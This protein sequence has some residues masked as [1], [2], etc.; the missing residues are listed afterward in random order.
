M[1]DA[2]GAKLGNDVPEGSLVH[3]AAA[4]GDGFFVYDVWESREA[5][6]RFRNEK[7]RPAIDE[8]SGGQ[9]GVDAD[10]MIWDLHDFR[11]A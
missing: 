3:T 1:Y 7:L 10:I 4:D 5:W 2:V 8:V 9:G 11:T 6:E